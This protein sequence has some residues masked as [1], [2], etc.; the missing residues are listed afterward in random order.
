MQCTFDAQAWINDYAVSVDPH[1]P[2]T[3]DCTAYAEEHAEYVR[4]IL[5]RREDSVDLDD[6]FAYDPAAPEWVQEWTGPFSIWVE[7]EPTP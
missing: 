2:T 6:V 3:W 1:G 4:D 7:E 5:A